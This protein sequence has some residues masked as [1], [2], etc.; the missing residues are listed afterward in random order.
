MTDPSF[1]NLEHLKIISL[2]K[3]LISLKEQVSLLADEKAILLATIARLAN[4]I[5]PME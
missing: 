5:Q 1:K 3:E 2:T 4:D